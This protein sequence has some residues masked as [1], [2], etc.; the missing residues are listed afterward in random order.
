MQWKWRFENKTFPVAPQI[1]GETLKELEST[2]G[3]KI[4]PET[5]VDAARPADSPLHKCFTWD[6]S[7]AAELWRKGQAKQLAVCVVPVQ[8]L[9]KPKQLP[10]P[11]IVAPVKQSPSP[12]YEVAEDKDTGKEII[13]RVSV[14][15]RSEQVRDAIGF[16]LDKLTMARE[17]LEPYRETGKWCAE[18]KDAEA[19]IR[20]FRAK[21]KAICEQLESIENGLVDNLR[22][23]RRNSTRREH[24]SVA[25]CQ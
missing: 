9:P 17:K 13:R 18:I 10:V 5:I 15:S 22:T 19:E 24:L 25:V 7:K 21:A 23:E 20:A 6:N 12:F 4:Q 2:S 3:G 14:P 8:D 16:A 11:V 1:I